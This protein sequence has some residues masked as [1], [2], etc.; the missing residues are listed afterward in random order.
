MPKSSASLQAQITAARKKK[1]LLHTSI[2]Y[3]VCSICSQLK[4]PLDFNS[5]QSICKPC[6]S[7]RNAVYRKK[8][9]ERKKLENKAP[10]KIKKTIPTK[11]KKK[12][13]KQHLLPFTSIPSSNLNYKKEIE[14]LKKELE[15][16]KLQR[17][18]EKETLLSI[19]ELYRK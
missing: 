15:H 2:N 17:K 6:Q 9:V 8:A 3:K 7:V 12:L 1:G 11:I 14:K 4:S 13:K 19:I 18:I 16:E 10:K 5:K